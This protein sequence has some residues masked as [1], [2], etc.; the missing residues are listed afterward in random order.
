M[1]TLIKRKLDVTS[2]IAQ[3]NAF[4][5][6]LA[7]TLNSETNRVEMNGR[8]MNRTDLCSYSNYEPP[9]VNKMLGFLYRENALVNIYTYNRDF[10]Y[11]NPAFAR[12]LD[13]PECLFDWLT[14]IFEQE[15]NLEDKELVYFRKSKGKLTININETLKEIL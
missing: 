15:H 8:A 5:F 4:Y 7:L 12:D 2:Y 1:I 14:D 6:M 13:T 10:F 3:V 9:Y 11:I